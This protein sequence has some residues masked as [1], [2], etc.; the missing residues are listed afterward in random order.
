MMREL[1]LEVGIPAWPVALEHSVGQ[2]H[3]QRQADTTENSADQ[4][5]EITWEE[6]SKQGIRQPLLGENK[7]RG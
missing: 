3:D 1:I 7:E 6:K 2:Y 5:L 4:L